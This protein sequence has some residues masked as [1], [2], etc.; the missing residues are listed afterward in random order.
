M[1]VLSLI[2]RSGTCRTIARKARTH[3]VKAIVSGCGLIS[4]CGFASYLHGKVSVGSRRLAPQW[5]VGGTFPILLFLSLKLP[6][7][8]SLCPTSFLSILTYHGKIHF[9]L[10]RVVF[11]FFLQKSGWYGQYPLAM[12]CAIGLS[13][14]ISFSL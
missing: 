14:I 10:T 4:G 3:V 12:F 2:R 9:L 7:P 6:S 8:P 11:A 1:Q 13:S 5:R